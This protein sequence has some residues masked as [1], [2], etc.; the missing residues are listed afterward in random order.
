MGRACPGRGLVRPGEL[1]GVRVSHPGAAYSSTEMMIGASARL[2]A[3]G[4]CEIAINAKKVFVIMPQS[5]RSFVERIDFITSPG[6][7]GGARP[8]GWGAGPI[9]VVTQLGVYRFDPGP[10]EIALATVH[11]GVTLDQI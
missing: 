10:G 2:L 9:A 8:G 1:R 11:P 5:L 3:G 6:R 7:L 4:A